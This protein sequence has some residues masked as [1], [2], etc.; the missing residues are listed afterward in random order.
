MSNQ[1][2]TADEI[3]VHGRGSLSIPYKVMS[4]SVQVDLS[5]Y[6]LFFEVNGALIRVALEVDPNDALGKLIVLHRTDVE[7]LKTVP[8]SFALVDE[9]GDRRR[10]SASPVGRQDFARWIYP[11]AGAL[12]MAVTTDIQTV[13]V[14]STVTS[15]GVSTTVDAPVAVS[16]ETGGG[17]TSVTEMQGPRGVA[18]R[19]GTNG[20]DGQT[21]YQAA[22]ANGFVGT[23]AAWL[24]SLHGADGING[25]NGT[26]GPSAYQVAVANGF[27]GTQ[28]AWLASLQ[29][30]AGAS[31]YQVAV[32]NGFVGT[33]AEWLASLQANVDAELAF[34]PRMTVVGRQSSPHQR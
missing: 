30:A 16:V 10:P 22:V 14:T 32:A 33:Q 4:G 26:D 11:F 27:V 17:T 15:N 12:T 34:R 2:V 19:D 28:A 24:A 20:T 6:S 29:G 3:I 9:T 25:T 7:K 1:T 21:A 13:V 5:T 31:A 8:L 23:E 18:G